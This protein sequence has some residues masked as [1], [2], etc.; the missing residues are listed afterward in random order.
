V[1]AGGFLVRPLGSLLFG[2]IGDHYGTAR[3]LQVRS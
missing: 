3:A 2:M 1:Y